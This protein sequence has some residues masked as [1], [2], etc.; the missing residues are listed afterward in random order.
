M[1]EDKLETA[2]K[3]FTGNDERGL[4]LGLE[5]VHLINIHR[6]GAS[7]AVVLCAGRLA[8]KLAKRLYE[9]ELG[10]RVLP[11]SLVGKRL[12]LADK[13]FFLNAFGCIGAETYYCLMGLKNLA[14]DA[15]HGDFNIEDDWANS[16]L[17][18]L[19]RV[20]AELFSLP[21][22]HTVGFP[23]Q[24]VEVTNKLELWA[25][26]ADDNQKVLR[27]L[28]AQDAAVMGDSVLLC[29]IAE[30]MLKHGPIPVVLEQA[31]LNLLNPRRRLSK[32]KVLELR[33]KE[34]LALNYRRSGRYKAAL[35]ILKPVLAKHTQV[36]GRDGH[37]EEFYGILGAVYKAMWIEEPKN[38]QYLRCALD[39]YK[40]AADLTRAPY[41][42]INAAAVS[43][44]LAEHE[45]SRK[46][47][48]KRESRDYAQRVCNLLSNSPQVRR[49]YWLQASLAE[50]H[51]LLGEDAQ[52][53]EAYRR[54]FKD[55]A[56]KPGDL[57]STRGQLGLILKI[58]RP[59]AS[60]DAFLS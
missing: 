58:T 23:R 26:L 34:L 36:Y 7:A 18:M 5:F 43:R 53:K 17:V 2:L 51:L 60:V 3:K 42:S 52:A 24:L 54:A 20:V 40:K 12:E 56:D 33:I 32:K 39:N 28:N 31:M 47:G 38:I 35:E 19:A 30:M 9:V 44:I 14:N 59:G 4:E 50:A 49:N 46:E 27:V 1:A 41:T 11:D 37:G 8:E 55:Y 13:I 22:Y 6:L 16:T 57:K 45:P 21:A 48:L 25:S 15:R 10:G 29:F